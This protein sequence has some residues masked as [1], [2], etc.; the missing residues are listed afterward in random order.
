MAGFR[1]VHSQW[2]LVQR[3]GNLGFSMALNI[4][5]VKVNHG[6]EE[7]R[8]ET[9]EWVTARDWNR[10]H[11]SSFE[12]YASTKKVLDARKEHSHCSCL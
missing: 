7:L 10:G 11:A 4:L 3:I 1:L 6:V 9:H 5:R 8:G 2:G 12:D